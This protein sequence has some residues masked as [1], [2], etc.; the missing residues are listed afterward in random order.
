MS[1]I[2]DKNVKIFDLNTISRGDLIRIRRVNE[3]VARNGFVTRVT[4][5]QLEILTSN[6]QN[7]AT[8]FI[9]ILPADVAVGVWEVWWT[10][11]FSVV[12]YENNAT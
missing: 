4:E 9:Q 11:D 12:N 8:S 1:L 5:S 2:T 7:N 6:I 10:T 3:T